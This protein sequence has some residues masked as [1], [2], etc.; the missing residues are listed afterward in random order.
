MRILSKYRDYYDYLSG[1][2]GED[3]KLI[4]D[5]REF[6]PQQYK[7][8]VGKV[9]LLICGFVY[10]GY[11]DGEKY[12]WGEDL[13]KV[14]EIEK[15]SRWFP[16]RKNSVYIASSFNKKYDWDYYKIEPFKDKKELN[17]VENCPILLYRY[18]DPSKF[19]ILKEWGIISILPPGKIYQMLVNWL[20]ERINEK[21]RGIGIIMTDTQ[22]LESKGFDKVTSFRPNIKK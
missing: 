4:L 2:W 12:Y 8:Q 19:P 6:T 14:G 15:Y 5:R 18:K 3:P 9:I 11:F 16:D 17:K 7:P 21:E 1:I 13:L 20:S 10:E 22:K